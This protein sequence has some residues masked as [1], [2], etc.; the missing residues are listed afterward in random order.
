MD[1]FVHVV[2]VLT[3]LADSPPTIFVGVLGKNK[4]W[5][6]K[7]KVEVWWCSKKK[8]FCSAFFTLLFFFLFG[9]IHLLYIFF[10]FKSIPNYSF[11]IWEILCCIHLIFSIYHN[12]RSL[13]LII[14][15][16][17]YLLSL[18]SGFF[19]FKDQ[20]WWIQLPNI[21]RNNLRLPPKS[22]CDIKKTY[23]IVKIQAVRRDYIFLSNQGRN[24]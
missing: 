3:A 20:F 19:F 5:N 15:F 17:S 8:S 6:K 9:R 11:T 1:S 10:I 7:N 13:V 4:N 16:F 18:M 2:F 21:S 23:H 14:L 12:V 24:S 22:A